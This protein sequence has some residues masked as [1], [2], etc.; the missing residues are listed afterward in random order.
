MASK[1]NPSRSLWNDALCDSKNGA[2]CKTKVSP[3][4]PE[5][6][7]LPTCE[8]QGRPDFV[9][10]N[11]AC[12]KW[13]DVPKTWDEAEEDC[14]HQHAHLVSITNDMEQ[15]YVFANSKQSQ[16]WIGLSNKQVSTRI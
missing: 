12:Y 2:L 5:P 6:P 13:M 4:V 9:K 15:S 10:F 11:G 8:D 7:V 3:S 1:E 16:V 14:K